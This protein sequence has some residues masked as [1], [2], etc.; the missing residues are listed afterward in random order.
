MEYAIDSNLTVSAIFS[1]IDIERRLPGANLRER[2]SGIGD[3]QL[4]FRWTA[5]DSGLT[6]EEQ[7]PWLADS[8]R[9]RLRV[10]FGVSLPTGK[11]RSPNL[12]IGGTPTSL[13]QT[14]SGTFQP[15][16]GVG[17]RW[18]WGG[19]ALTADVQSTLPFYENDN[20]FQQGVSINSSLGFELKPT[21]GLILRIAIDGDYRKR[22]LQF[23]DRIEPGGGLRVAAHPVIIWSPIEE[24]QIFAGVVLP[25]YRNVPQRLLDTAAKVEFGVSFVF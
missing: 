12:S 10:S 15:L 13:L 3:T 14:G 22:D 11:T 24:L 17:T 18:D 1:Y 7:I 21:D 8:P 5:I 19:I 16:L 20:D 9:F 2:V 6:E 25:F 4:I 23:G